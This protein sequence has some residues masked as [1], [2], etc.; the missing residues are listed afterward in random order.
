MTRTIRA[1]RI[2]NV[3]VGILAFALAMASVGEEDYPLALVN[4]AL[5]VGNIFMFIKLGD[6][7]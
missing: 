4:I 6:M 3:V 2:S 5:V 7:A 1:V